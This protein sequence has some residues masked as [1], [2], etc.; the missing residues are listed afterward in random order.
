MVQKNLDKKIQSLVAQGIPQKQLPFVT[1]YV[2][3]YSEK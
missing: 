3:Y 2:S 1:G